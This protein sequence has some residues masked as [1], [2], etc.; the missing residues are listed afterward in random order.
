MKDAQNTGTIELSLMSSGDLR[1]L[2]LEEVAYVKLY[3]TAGETAWVVHAADGTAV[4]VQP[5]RDA[6][7]M[8]AQYQELDVVSLH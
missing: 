8:S 5:T 3:K 7:M 4:A 2:G 6:A 1:K